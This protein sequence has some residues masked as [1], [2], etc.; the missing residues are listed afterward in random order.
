MARGIGHELQDLPPLLLMGVATDEFMRLDD[1]G[2]ECLRRLG[3]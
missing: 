1:Q 2:E 3:G